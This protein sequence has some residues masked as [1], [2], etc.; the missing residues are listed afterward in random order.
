[1]GE[2]LAHVPAERQTL[3]F[4]AKQ[5]DDVASLAALSFKR[6]PIYVDADDGDD[7]ATARSLSQSSFTIAATMKL[8]L[9]VT[10]LERNRD[11][12]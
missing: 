2:I 9:L 7:F 8:L 12:K 4:S 6:A 5:K 3:L 10:I 11:K 1:M